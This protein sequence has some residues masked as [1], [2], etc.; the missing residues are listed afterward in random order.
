MNAQPTAA[1]MAAR[2]T[3]ANTFGMATCLSCAMAKGIPPMNALPRQTAKAIHHGLEAF[4]HLSHTG[5]SVVAITVTTP[6]LAESVNLRTEKSLDMQRTQKGGKTAGRVVW[7]VRD[8]KWLTPK[9]SHSHWR[10]TE[11]CKLISK[12]HGSV[13]TEGAVAVG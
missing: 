6:P 10:R 9:L 13:K 2:R 1:A 3:N 8:I 7:I 5:I 11:Q 12:F 4:Q